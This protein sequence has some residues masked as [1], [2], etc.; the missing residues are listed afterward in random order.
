MLRPAGLWNVYR[1]IISQ[2]LH[3]N[4]DAITMLYNKFVNIVTCR[5]T[6]QKFGTKEWLNNKIDSAKYEMDG[7]QEET[8]TNLY[9]YH[10]A[11]SLYVALNEQSCSELGART[12]AMDGATKNAGEMIAKLTLNYNRRRQAGIT[13]ELCEIIGGAEAIKAAD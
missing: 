6:A 10:L 7:M 11:A 13:T 3:S 2:V 8:L 12:T 9:E 1:A 5:L 4:Y